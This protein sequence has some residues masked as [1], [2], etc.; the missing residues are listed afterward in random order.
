MATSVA[1]P[2]RRNS[3]QLPPGPKGWP[4]IGVTAALVKDPLNFFYGTFK[5]YGDIAHFHIG[6][7]QFYMLNHPDYVQYVLQGNHRNYRKGVNYEKLHPLLGNGLVTSDGEF[8]LRQRR[9]I[10]PAFHRKRLAAFSTVMT[11]AGAEMLDRWETYARDGQPLD[12]AGEFM[13]VTLEVVSRSMFSTDAAGFSGEIGRNLP[14]VLQRTNARF[15][16]LFDLSS[17]PTPR[18]RRYWKALEALDRVVYGVIDER[19]RSRVA[20]DDLLTM[21]LEA[22]DE[23]SGERMTD[24]QL[25]DEVMTI[26]LAG[27][28]TT[29]NALSWAQYLIAQHPEVESKLHAE[30]DAVLQG[31][32]PTVEDL[33]ALAY[34]RMV[35]DEVLRLY[36]SV[37]GIARTPIEPDE[38]GGYRIP[39]GVS[40]GLTAYITHRHP[41]FWDRPEAFDPERFSAERS[42]GRH[43]FA[44]FPFG[45]GPRLCIG[46]NFALME[47]TLILAMIAGR[48]RLELVPDRIVVP[49]PVVTL[50]PRDGIW[51][52]VRPR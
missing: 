34:T 35:I 49:Q 31:R 9:L 32:A 36:P 39:A 30:A 14:I 4:V 48:Y 52:R 18:N 26:Y 5:E 47:A 11:D 13:R 29:A 33:P 2:S 1:I 50:R 25:R 19:R 20:F 41:A 46:N 44:Y 22:V 27:H 40:V 21:L 42:A 45:G 17:L 16:E 24:R 10:Q 37:W 3:I 7:R 6:N 38:I 8:W 15:W 12:V 43:P 28:E 51:M 23:D